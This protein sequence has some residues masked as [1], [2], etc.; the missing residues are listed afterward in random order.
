MRAFT[1]VAVAV[2]VSAD[3]RADWCVSG[4]SASGSGT[5]CFATQGECLTWSSSLGPHVQVGACVP[6]GTDANESAEPSPDEERAARERAEEEAARQAEDDAKWA[7]ETERYQRF[8]SW[9]SRLVSMRYRRI[10]QRDEDIYCNP[11]PA[12]ARLKPHPG[13][14]DDPED[15]AAYARAIARWEH[16]MQVCAARFARTDGAAAPS[17]S[18]PR[19]GTVG[20]SAPP[21]ILMEF[22]TVTGKS[23]TCEPEDTEERWKCLTDCFFATDHDARPLGAPTTTI[24]PTPPPAGDTTPR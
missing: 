23:C 5:Q 17:P 7:H 6:T 15:R 10:S 1:V 8:A 13:L 12:Q 9:A 20:P 4:S 19:S 21:K 3:A 22:P 24:P 11:P 2:I 18:P 14:S 16:E